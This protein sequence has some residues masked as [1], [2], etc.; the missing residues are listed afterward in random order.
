M[1]KLVI[2]E[3]YRLQ[4]NSDHLQTIDLKVISTENCAEKILLS[5]VIE[6]HLCTMTKQGE[7]VCYVR[8]HKI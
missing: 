7:G 2:F 8:K 3:I 5:P 4:K 1:A 6:S